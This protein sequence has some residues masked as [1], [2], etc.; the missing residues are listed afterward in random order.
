MGEYRIS[1]FIVTI[2][3]FSVIIEFFIIPRLNA[4]PINLHNMIMHA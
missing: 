3:N 4:F 1:I 2:N